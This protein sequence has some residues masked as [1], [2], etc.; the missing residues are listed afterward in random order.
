MG[1]SFRFNADVIRK[2][3]GRFLAGGRFAGS[4]RSDFLGRVRNAIHGTKEDTCLVEATHVG[5]ASRLIREK[6]M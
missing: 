4:T 3:G 6:A 2:K 5:T 1:F